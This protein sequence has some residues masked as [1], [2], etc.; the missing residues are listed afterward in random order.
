LQL[1]VVE[2]GNDVGPALI[3]IN[4]IHHRYAKEKHGTN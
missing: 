3:E 2:A 4:K 1:C